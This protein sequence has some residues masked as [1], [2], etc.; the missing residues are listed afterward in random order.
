MGGGTLGVTAIRGGHPDPFDEPMNRPLALPAFDY[1]QGCTNAGTT[2]G[3]YDTTSGF[4][5][6]HSGG[7][8]FVFC[9]GSVQFVRESIT[10]AAYRAL[11]TIAGGEVMGNE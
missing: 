6:L 7:C 11:S 4:R 2:P 1:N 8:Q 5:S 10:P 9:D 3:T